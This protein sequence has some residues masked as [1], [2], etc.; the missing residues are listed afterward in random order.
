MSASA[1]STNFDID[2]WNLLSS[3]KL[4][5]SAFINAFVLIRD[6]PSFDIV[7]VSPSA[8]T[9]AAF[10]TSSSSVLKPETT[11]RPNCR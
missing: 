10:F 2:W 3:S 9:A 6:W 8:S 1:P 7:V 4:F 5:I 11:C